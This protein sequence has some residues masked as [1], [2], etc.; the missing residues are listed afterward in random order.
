[1]TDPIPTLRPLEQEIINRSN[2]AAYYMVRNVFKMP[3]SIDVATGVMGG[4]KSRTIGRVAELVNNP[5]TIY[6]LSGDRRFGSND[7]SIGARNMKPITGDIRPVGFGC[8]IDQVL[9]DITSGEFLPGHVVGMVEGAFI[10]H[11]QPDKVKKL[12]EE[13]RRRNLHLKVDSLGAWHSTHPIA[14]TLAFTD[15]ADKVFLMH[16]WDDLEPHKPADTNL[17][18]VGID[19]NGEI[20][21]PHRQDAIFLNSI[22]KE[23]RLLMIRNLLKSGYG[24]FIRMK[25]PEGA[26]W[27]EECYGI[28]SHPVMDTNLA[29][30]ADRY[31]SLTRHNYRLIYSTTGI[32]IERA[33]QGFLE[34]TLTSKGN[35]HNW[36]HPS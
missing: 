1:M 20:I 11:G 21:E 27:I 5:V 10:A 13:V 17:R 19:S 31:R 3:S 12:G 22:N 18:L 35:L 8:G 2:T 32:N 30:G 34:A 28:P 24:E 9:T 15:I 7:T 4:A 25:N 36:M 16:A 23:L 14:E 33:P 6:K 26:D 29:L